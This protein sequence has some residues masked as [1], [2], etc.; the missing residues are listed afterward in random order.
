MATK[1]VTALTFVNPNTLACCFGHKVELWDIRDFSK[2][3]ETITVRPVKILKKKI[4]HFYSS[5][6]FY[7]YFQARSESILCVA[8]S[9]DFRYL[10]FGG[11]SA[12]WTYDLIERKDCHAFEN[13]HTGT[14]RCVNFDHHKPPRKATSSSDDK[15]AV[16]FD[17][18]VGSQIGK[19]TGFGANVRCS[20]FSPN[21]KYVMSCSDDSSVKI[22]NST[23]LEVIKTRKHLSSVNFGDWISNSVIAFGDD[24]HSVNLW[25]FWTDQI[26]S[27]DHH[28]GYIRC[29]A[30]RF[31]KKKNSEKKII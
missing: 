15:T 8:T 28:T 19:V 23:T 21:G 6:F 25:C 1:N 7:Y 24:R 11:G 31:L 27:E 4:F 5:F 3:K 16:V 13:V 10:I 2:A 29:L 22:S 18:E 12:V 14:I 26:I 9:D 17:L 30:L 20:A